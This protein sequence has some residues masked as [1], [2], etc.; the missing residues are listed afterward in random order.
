MGLKQ[1]IILAVLMTL[2][3]IM[4]GSSGYWL[5]FMGRGRVGDVERAGDWIRKQ[6][7]H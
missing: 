1:R 4:L 2:G 6:R 3:V 5:M 7:L